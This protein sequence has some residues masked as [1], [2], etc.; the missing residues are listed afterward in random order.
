MSE[1][2]YRDLCS[3]ETLRSGKKGFFRDFSEHA[4]R[5]AGDDWISK[6][7]AR[8]SSDE[9]RI[10][11]V[12][13]DE[14]IKDVVLETLRRVRALF[15][16]KDEGIAKQRR[17]EAILAAALGERERARLLFSQAILRAP[18]GE[19]KML[20]EAGSTLSLALL[21]RAQ[22]F[23]ASKEYGRALEDLKRIEQNSLREASAAEV[24]RLRKECQR[25]LERSE[26]GALVAVAAG[27]EASRREG[28]LPVLTA[29][30]N[31]LHPNASA[32]I[33]I[34][35]SSEAGK[36][37]VAAKSIEPGDVLVVEAPLAACLLPEYYGTHCHQCFSRLRA[38][39]GCPNCS[40]VAF[41]GEECKDL[42]A[43][44]YHKSG[45][46]SR[47][48]PE[49]GGAS[50]PD[51]PGRDFE[52]END[53]N[54]DLRAYRLVM[55]QTERSAKDFLERSL[56]AAFML[57][58]LQR[59]GFFEKAAADDGPLAE[60]EVAIGS[61]LLKNLQ[62]LQFNAHEVFET[63]LGSDHLFRGSKPLYVGV[64][65][66]PTV[67]RFNHDCYPAVTRYFAE[68]NIVIRA[69]RSLRPGDVVAENYGPIFTKRSLED[70]RRTLAGR[71]WFRC[72][73][74]ACRED[75][76][77]IEDLSNDTA[78]L[79]CPTEGC[80]GRHP[81]ARASLVCSVCKRR[82]DLE[83]PVARLEECERSY[84]RGLMAMDEERPEEAIGILIESA[85][86]FH[87]VALPPHRDTHLAEIGLSACMAHSGNTWRPFLP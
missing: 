44:S 45:D 14:R 77:R 52:A 32:L 22:V 63:R 56:M 1:E 81:R 54:V 74:T 58:C 65:I 53:P 6:I 86:D 42:A 20:V 76:P 80:C 78:E 75:W 46:D 47:G 11:A 29:G 21:G 67:A 83:G 26:S 49:V 3:A 66:Y 8:L 30:A 69:T 82:V 17:N 60:E 40:T 7:F 36:R 33:E 71:Y 23:F 72:A 84:A 85:I 64:A 15:R 79:R 5:T 9:E 39:V 24:S 68:R 2:S 10:S 28:L 73:C 70:R 25:L 37:V 59:V 12:F 55:H 18:T 62:L 50:P 57:K 87:K 61:L 35:E 31:S 34:Q 51:D 41:C 4:M 13:T 48:S 27:R 16:G 19:G 38:P 43:S